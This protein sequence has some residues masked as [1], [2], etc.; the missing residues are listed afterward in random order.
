MLFKQFG[1]LNAFTSYASAILELAGTQ[2]KLAY[3]LSPIVFLWHSFK[4]LIFSL[5]LC[6]QDLLRENLGQ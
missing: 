1:G 2:R 5:N 4:I 6:F 3:W